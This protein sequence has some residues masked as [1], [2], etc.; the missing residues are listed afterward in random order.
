MS[1]R[2]KL[3]RKVM[4]PPAVKG[5]KP[6]G[7]YAQASGSGCV[8]LHFEEYESLKLCDYDMYTHHQASV[9]MGVSRPT[10][11]RIYA[12]ARQKIARAFVEGLKVSIEGGKV[13]F[14]SDWYLCKS[15]ECFFNNPERD[16]Q[17]EACPLCGSRKV[18]GFDAQEEI[19]IE[20]SNRCQDYC[21]CPACGYEE[22]HKKG[23]P[24]GQMICPH[25]QTR[26]TRKGMKGRRR[27]RKH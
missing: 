19:H 27:N 26:M 16:Q 23:A 17:I 22:P 12:S 25:C 20:Y 13:F 4:A 24:C 1:P 5:F 2:R 8:D 10:F 18:S 6:Y 11:T 7:G 15:C 21:L 3:L 9:L 14:D